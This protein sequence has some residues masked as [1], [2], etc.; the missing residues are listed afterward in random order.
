MLTLAK[1]A[2]LWDE[3]S[4]DLIVSVK[5]LPTTSIHEVAQRL[6][7]E[8]EDGS[9]EN[10]GNYILHV[11]LF[12]VCHEQL[13]CRNGI[14]VKNDSMRKNP[15]DRPVLGAEG[16]YRNRL[17]R[18]DPPLGTVS[19]GDAASHAQNDGIACRE[20]KCADSHAVDGAHEVFSLILGRAM[21][22][23]E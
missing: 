12:D 21:K 3:E 9:L 2:L 7:R 14:L 8:T 5:T 10:A 15:C 20:A 17:G 6:L 16:E 1:T 13:N 23:S 4:T 22:M 19:S 11:R 18:T